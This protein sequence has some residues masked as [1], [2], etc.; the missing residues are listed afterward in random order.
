MITDSL[1]LR[2]YHGPR[3]RS[4]KA[5]DLNRR[6]ARRYCAAMLFHK[7]D[8]VQ[9]PVT[10]G[11]TSVSAYF[12]TAAIVARYRRMGYDVARYYA[13]MDQIELRRCHDT[14][15]RFFYP[16]SL[17]GEADFYDQILESDSVD[18]YRAWS[19]DYQF[20]SDRIG[21]GEAVLDVGCGYGKFLAAVAGRTRAVGVD[22]NRKAQARCLAAGLDVRLGHVADHADELRGRFDVATAFHILEHVWDV[23]SF[24]SS[25]VDALKPGGRLIIA[26]PNNEPYFL[27]FDKYD[28]LNT[29]PHHVG[30]WNKASLLAIAPH[31][32]LEAVEHAYL[33]VARR[34][35]VDAYVR[36]RYWAGVKTEIHHHSP[37]ELARIG[38]FAAPA[39]IAS[40]ARHIMRG[41]ISSRNASV[42]VYRKN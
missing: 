24:I 33:E 10:G 28:T 30:L 42:I 11:E 20:A 29:P 38:L 17:A 18:Y 2:R 32:G 3:E 9:S 36:A 7:V 34:P 16:P 21:D 14:G 4:R 22:G 31:F 19:E 27:S 26:V 13:G 41:G 15:Y 6:G 8:R 39:V 12:Q 25:A 1:M 23:R 40:F 5:G 35:L 37:G